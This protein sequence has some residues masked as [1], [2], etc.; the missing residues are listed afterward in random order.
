MSNACSTVASAHRLAPNVSQPQFLVHGLSPSRWRRR[1]ERVPRA[2]RPNRHRVRQCR[3]PRRRYRR[4]LNGGA[5]HC[6]G[7]RH[8]FADGAS[9]R[10]QV[11]RNADHRCLGGVG[12]SH[13]ARSRKHPMIR[14]TEVISPAIRPPVQLS[15]VASISRLRRHRSISRTARS[16]NLS[17]R[18]SW[19][20]HRGSGKSH[21]AFLAADGAKFFHRRGLDGDA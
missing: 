12:I 2:L 17:I 9:S 21:D 13:E 6:H 20:P 4:L 16:V 10:D 19:Q 7:P 11:R 15:A 1:N 5:P 18:T 8:V 3:S 14:R